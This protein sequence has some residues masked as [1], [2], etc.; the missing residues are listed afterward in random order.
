MSGLL[1]S[2]L[3]DSEL[4]R[5][6]QNLDLEFLSDLREV[7]LSLNFPNSDFSEEIPFSLAAEDNIGE[8]I[9]KYSKDRRLSKNQVYFYMNEIDDSLANLVIRPGYTLRE[10]IAKFIKNGG[11]EIANRLLS[12]VLGVVEQDPYLMGI[13]KRK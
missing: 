10:S 6:A 5:F 13:T 8:I 9:L 7:L 12:R 2:S 3:S 4:K 1:A 11:P